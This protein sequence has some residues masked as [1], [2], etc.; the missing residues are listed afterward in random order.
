MSSARTLRLT[1]Q[2]PLQL[3]DADSS[4]KLTFK[5]PASI[6]NDYTIVMPSAIA[7]GYLKFDGAGNASIDAGTSSSV[8]LDASYHTGQTVQ[9]DIN[10]TPLK[11][12][13]GAS[14]TG[15]VFAVEQAGA[16]TASTISVLAGAA[17]NPG[18]KI[19]MDASVNAAAIEITQGNG[20]DAIV[21]L[22]ADIRCE[23]L[24]TNGAAGTLSMDNTH[25]IRFRDSGGVTYRTAMTLDA[26]NVLKIGTE[27]GGSGVWPVVIRTGG[28][29]LFR[30]GAGLADCT[31]F[32][33]LIAPHSINGFTD[34]SFKSGVAG[35]AMSA[36][37]R[38][39]I[40]R[41]SATQ[42]SPTLKSDLS[43]YINTGNTLSRTLYIDN[44]G[45]VAMGVGAG[46]TPTASLYVLTDGSYK[47]ALF[48]KQAGDTN[49]CVGVVQN[50]NAIGLE[51]DKVGSGAGTALLISNSG[52]GLDIEGTASTWSVSK[53]GAAI[54]ST[55]TIGGSAIL[56]SRSTDPNGVV[57]AAWGSIYFHSQPVSGQF[58]GWS[59]VSNPSGSVWKAF[60]GIAL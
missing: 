28:T 7:A 59:C 43:L 10:N 54:F 19:T 12:Q 40:L 23:Q 51:V 9:V 5:A 35:D 4:N 1:G 36:S 48:Q 13:A 29:E 18:L 3:F 15:T 47:G 57:T 46:T 25:Q 16:G 44:Q 6:P 2:G 33:N 20:V 41:S 17:N 34:L 30:V 24:I 56:G 49:V 14:Y 42:I 45:R 31:G 22:G 8:T 53:T 39:A 58:I 52:T 37:N 26:S 60:G 50:A 27:A 11:V 55:T 38:I 32:L 21:A